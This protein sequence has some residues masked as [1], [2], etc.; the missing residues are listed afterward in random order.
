LKDKSVKKLNIQLFSI[1][2]L[3]RGTNLELGRDADT[4]GQVKYVVDLAKAL[5]EHPD[6]KQVDLFTRLIDDKRVS[7]DYREPIES[8]GESARIIRVKCG[9]SRYV[10]KELLWPHLDEFVDNVIQFSKKE[11]QLPDVVHG[12]YA[13]GGY[14]ARQISGMLGL[15]LIFTGHS[16][17]KTKSRSLAGEGMAMEE[18]DKKFN[19]LRRIK[20][21]ENVLKQAHMVVTST[22]DEIERQYSLYSNANGVNFNIIPPGIDLNGFYPFYYDQ[23]ENFTKSEELLQARHK[24]T[25]ELSRFLSN[26]GKPMI[27]AICRPDS[28]KNI[29][30]L[31]TA[32]GRHKELQAL[33]NLAIFAGIRKDID[34]MDDNESNVL[35]E[36][37]LLM[38]KYDLYG[39][40]AIPKKH[41]P[42]YEV[43][44]LYRMA[45]GSKGVFVN[46]AF[47]EPFGLTMI[48]AAASG[49]PIVGPDD[50]GPVE[51]VKNCR[52]GLIVDTRE[53]D[54]IAKAI[55]DILIDEEKWISYSNNG[56]QGVRK[57]YS[58]ESHAES[59][60]SGYKKVI[61]SIKKSG[62]D[63]NKSPASRFGSIRKLFI[64]DID[65]TLTGDDKALKELTKI[66]NNNRESF[67]F[68]V[69]SG[70][71]LELIREIVEAENLPLPDVIISSV[72][73]EIHYGQD[74][75]N[76]Q[77]DEGWAAH[78]SYQWKPEMIRNVLAELDFLEPQEDEAQKAFKLSYLMD[79]DQDNIALIHQKLAEAKLRYSLIYSHGAFLDMI[80][81]RASKG[82]AL[83]YLGKKWDIPQNRILVAGDSGND[84]EMLQGKRPA[85][86]VGNYSDELAGLKGNR[87]VY[88]AQ[89]NYAAGVIEGM[90]QYGYIE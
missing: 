7:P 45:A 71:S 85:I 27:L 52:N 66:I 41:D 47:N 49:V 87:Q 38:D 29:Q 18:M 68:G 40:M 73:T 9:G 88:F 54:N 69:A 83:D 36:L 65:N 8:I 22:K 3:I 44:E 21:E 32:F 72:G 70:R 53:P 30:G 4:G 17:G 2:G 50:G 51:I 63:I 34:N 6:V 12:H 82:R 24:M 26:P 42:N 56:I 74:F 31:V 55:R 35:T 89:A 76:L 37:L 60:V 13:D 77:F 67:G 33:A 75:D 10:R 58:W 61:K 80:P 59:L 86:V 62:I 81:Q 11:G 46:S 90:K 25:H 20:A 57:H 28:K 15:P 1:H 79:Y 48:E 19:I 78:I 84:E 23:D 39:K 14:V 64:S 16:L 5:G 43:P